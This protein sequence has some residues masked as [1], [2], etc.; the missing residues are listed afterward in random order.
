MS[1]PPNPW[2]P[3]PEPEPAPVGEAENCPWPQ[4]QYSLPMPRASTTYGSGCLPPI[5]Y[6][7][8]L[9]DG[10]YSSKHQGRGT[11]ADFQPVSRDTTFAGLASHN[12]PLLESLVSSGAFPSYDQTALQGLG[13]TDLVYGSHDIIAHQQG[14]LSYAG[15]I[16]PFSRNVFWTAPNP[17]GSASDIAL[18][19]MALAPPTINSPQER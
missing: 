14:P 8:V 13:D 2:E 15:D 16:N 5:M 7:S 4:D 3:E 6:N 12:A 1:V 17:V 10:D 19:D 9:V 18:R 11:H